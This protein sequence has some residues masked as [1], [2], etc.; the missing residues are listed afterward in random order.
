MKYKFEKVEKYLYRRQ[1]QTADGDWSAFYYG[2]F[3]DWQ[4]T[5]RNFCLGDNLE[6]ARNRL[7]E[8]RRL[9]MGRYD[10]DKEKAEKKA[11]KVKAMTVAEWLDRYLELM[12]G[13]ASYK[14]KRAQCAPLKRLLG[15]LPL[16]E[17]TRVRILEYKNRRGSESL[18]RHGQ[19]VEGTTIQGAT[20]NREVS[21]LI[22]ALNL[23]ADDGLC[24][25]AP[26]IRKERE[27]ARERTLTD[28]EYQSLLGASD[29]WL[30]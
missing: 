29:R 23:A 16:A 8:L 22:T 3:V 12:T 27:M 6:T 4:K 9:N 14:T 10:F 18:V 5:R 2:N 26:R 15:H 28:K 19:A 13:T 7:G 30:Q 20:V 11:A 24:E 17:V 25:G 21:C 1:Y